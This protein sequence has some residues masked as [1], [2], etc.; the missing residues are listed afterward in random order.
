[1][2]KSLENMDFRNLRI[3]K[4]QNFRKSCVPNPYFLN[5]FFDCLILEYDNMM[6]SWKVEDEECPD[7]NV[8]LIKC[9]KAW[10]WI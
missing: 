4:S 5:I 9:T 8:P 1:M 6:K 2:E 7:I 3:W 10:I